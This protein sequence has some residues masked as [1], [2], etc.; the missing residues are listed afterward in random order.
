MLITHLGQVRQQLLASL[1]PLT[2]DQLNARAREGD[3][4]S[5]AAIVQHLCH[6]EAE[7]AADVLAALATP[8]GPVAERDPATLAAGVG[9]HHC[10][11]PP[12]RQPLIKANLVGALEQ[13]RFGSLQQIF[14]ETHVSELA[15]KSVDHPVYGP[16]SLKNL[17]DTIWLHEQWHLGQIEALKPKLQPTPNPQRGNRRA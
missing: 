9:A 2:D 3:A 1:R 8:R 15:E 11:I 17:I 6:S 14:N 13:S 12:L 10:T 16:I 7:V 4:P 5:I